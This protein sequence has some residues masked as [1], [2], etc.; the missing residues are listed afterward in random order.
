MIVAR[1]SAR[2]AVRR[3]STSAGVDRARRSR[4]ARSTVAAVDLP[5]VVQ[6]G[7]PVSDTGDQGGVRVGLHH[8]GDRAGV[9]EDPRDLLGAGRLVDR[10]GDRAGGP[11]GV[12]EQ[13][14]LVP[15]PAHQRRPGRR[16]RC[17]PRSARGPRAATSS[18]NSA[19]VTSRQRPSALRGEL[20]R[21]RGT[22]GVV[23][24]RIGQV[25]RVADRRDRRHRE[26]THL[27]TSPE[28]R[29][30]E[31]AH[32]EPG[33]SPHPTGCDAAPACDLSSPDR[34]RNSPRWCW[35]T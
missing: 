35:P 26:L 17:R 11:D 13:R 31:L 8:D 7:Q 32:S 28:P 34:R 14:P 27:P 10:H 9:R 12:V 19:Q 3:C 33:G 16:A 2:T 25:G 15:G 21:L 6:L 20:R 4:P 5:D 1:S 29:R 30:L 24:D 22:L 23:P 18:R